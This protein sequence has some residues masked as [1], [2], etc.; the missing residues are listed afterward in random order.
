MPSGSAAGTTLK[1]FNV[2]NPDAKTLIPLSKKAILVSRM[3]SAELHSDACASYAFL[4][5]LMFPINRTMFNT[6]ERSPTSSP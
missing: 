6:A 4:F 5:L 3:D 2:E 1:L